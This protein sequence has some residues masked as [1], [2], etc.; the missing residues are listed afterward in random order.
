M[1]GWSFFILLD[2]VTMLFMAKRLAVFLVI[3]LFGSLVFKFFSPSVP[4]V[5]AY[6]TNMS[7]DV[8]IGQRDFTNLST[9]TTQS[10]LSG[11]VQNSIIVNGKLIIADQANSR[12]LIWNSIPTTNGVSADIVVGQPDFTSS[13]ANNG[14]ISARTFD[15]PTTVISDGQKL[16]VSDRQNR[17]VLIW[18]NIPSINFAPAD[19]VVGQ[20]GFTTI[21]SNTTQNGLN[22]PEAVFTHAGKLYIADSTNNRVLIYNSIPTTNQAPADVV[23]GQVDF[24]TGTENTGGIG[25]NTLKYPTAVA[26]N[27]NKFI[28]TDSENHRVLIWNS[29]PTTNGVSANVVVGQPNFTSSIANQGG[30]VAPNTLSSPIGATV[31]EKG[32]LYIGDANHR[33]LIFNSIPS[34]SNTSADIVLGQPDFVSNT[35]NNGGRSANSLNLP[36]FATPYEQKLFVADAVNR[37]LL[38]FNNVVS[39]PVIGLRSSPEAAGDGRLRMRGNVRL[40][41]WGRYSLSSSKI[42]VSVNGGGWG[43]VSSLYGLREDTHDNLYEFYQEFDPHTGGVSSG[44]D[45]TLKFHA[46][47][48]NADES[49]SFYFTPFEIKS[50]TSGVF[51]SFS[52]K[53]N[54]DQFSRVSDNLSEYEVQV[55]KITSTGTSISSSST[56]GA[57]TYGEWT[58][59][60]DNIP[61]NLSSSLN[62][63]SLATTFDEVN[64][65]I[66]TRSKVKSLTAGKYQVKLVAVDDWGGRQETP[67]LS[68]ST[69]GGVTSTVVRP[70][71]PITSGFFPL[72]INGIRGITSGIIST[73]IYLS[74]SP[75]YFSSTQTPSLTGIAFS[76]SEVSL[77]ATNKNN[78]KQF[79]T[80]TAKVNSNSTY[81]LTPSLYPQSIIDMWVTDKDGRYNELPPFE[82]RVLE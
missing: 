45:Y 34:S 24:T 78:S 26:T 10:T 33:I 35:A 72:Q 56:S 2:G 58:T 53:V 50:I 8:V 55:R 13:T 20:P 6:Y 17:R 67:T 63:G 1:T 48:S 46:F 60:L 69:T 37:R 82:V 28:I 68:F 32:R 38:I 65:T 29:I 21:T 74:T 77:T 39:P 23:V 9:G 3:L 11:G 59:Y 43:E 80:Y 62:Q 51:P 25:P 15:N 81:T 47:S 27:G 14:G 76:G 5:Q 12:V 19:V 22:R 52:F 7:A 61:V 54:K 66:T 73:L 40:G 71:Y 75:I 31:D 44:D 64:G 4:A 30:S 49:Y 18:N 16:L 70:S 42:E 57:T 36:I 41:E 79:K